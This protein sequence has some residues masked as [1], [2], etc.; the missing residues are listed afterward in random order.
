MSSSSQP[1]PSPGDA[2][3]SDEEERPLELTPGWVAVG[4]VAIT[5]GIV[6]GFIMSSVWLVR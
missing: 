6:M 2:P 5:L 1:P 4:V 3:C